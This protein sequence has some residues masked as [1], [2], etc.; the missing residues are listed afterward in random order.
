[1]D[2]EESKKTSDR[3]QAV[4]AREAKEG[5]PRIG[6]RRPYGYVRDMSEQVDHEVER[7]EGAAGRV[8]AGASVWGICTDW[9]K[10]DV[11]TVTGKAWTVQTLTPILTSPRIAGFR[12]HRGTVVGVGQWKRIVDEDRHE[13]LVAALAIAAAAVRAFA[14]PSQTADPAAPPVAPNALRRA[15][16]VDLLAE[17]R[18]EAV[19]EAAESFVD[20]AHV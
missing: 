20:G 15:G 12:T 1:M 16:P 4:R 17:D 2:G 18:I 5:I 14:T 6:G 13:A 7:I 9:N 3:M 8:L 10:N 11:P 19:R